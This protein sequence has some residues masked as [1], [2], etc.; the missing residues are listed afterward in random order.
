MLF[1]ILEN[2]GLG[3]SE[4]CSISELGLKRS[5]STMVF[6]EEQSFITSSWSQVTLG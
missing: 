5:C 4:K 2:N 3:V 6:D 1:Q